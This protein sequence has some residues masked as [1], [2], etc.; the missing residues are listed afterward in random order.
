WGAGSIIGCDNVCVDPNPI[1]QP[2]IPNGDFELG[3]FGW[4]ELGEN[5]TFEYPTDGGNPGGYG[6]MTHSTEDEFALWVANGGA[7]LALAELGIEPGQLITFRQDMRIISGDMIGGMKIE[8]LQGATFLGQTPDLRPDLIGDG[9][10]WETY[11]FDVTIDPAADHIKVVPL[12]GPASS[13]G[14]D[15]VT[16]VQPAEELF[17]A[18]IELGTVVNWVP[19]GPNLIHQPQGSEDEIE[20]D[21]IGEAIIGDSP[22]SLFVAG[23]FP[24]Y[25]VEVREFVL[26][27]ATLNGGFESDGFSDPPCAEFWTCFSP[28]NQ[29]PTRITTDARTGEA[30]I[31]IA[32]QNDDGGTPNNSEIQQNI[33]QV[34]GFITPGESY[35]FSFWAK[36]ISSGTSYVQSYR[37]Q[38][39]D[40]GDIILP[41]G[42]QFTP[43]TGGDGEWKEIKVTDLVP[44]LEA[45]TAYIQIFG[46]TGAVA[47]EDARG[48]VLIDDLSLATVSVQPYDIIDAEL[49]DGLQLTWDTET[50]VSYQVQSSPVDLDSFVDFG[51][52]ISGDGE[53]AAISDS[54]DSEGNFYR[55]QRASE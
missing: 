50:G 15:N 44:P 7:P 45:V 47:G 18:D 33:N 22:S 3:S 41:G 52:P 43:F 26:E 11:S 21:D 2:L 12:W 49:A 34:G 14:Y 13:V 54:R 37:V 1:P 35:E 46:A 40:G 36:Q 31:R 5:T 32:V 53:P 23:D 27:S 39:L 51:A 20:W 19:E 38:W 24:F 10:T 30:S 48:E 29:P 25:R 8:F 28:S 17:V 6:I 4:F 16:F 55:V 42:T 9:S